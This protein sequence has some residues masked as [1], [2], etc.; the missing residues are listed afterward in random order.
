MDI[1]AIVLVVEGLIAHL[2]ILY[3]IFHFFRLRYK[4][5]AFKPYSNTFSIL[6][7]GILLLNIGGSTTKLDNAFPDLFGLDLR[8][9]IFEPFIYTSTYITYIG[10]WILGNHYLINQ[11]IKIPIQRRTS[12]FISQRLLYILLFFLITI[13]PITLGTFF[14]NLLGTDH[15]T[16]IYTIFVLISQIS[17]FTF[18]FY[19]KAL[20][21]EQE[22]NI[23]KLTKARIDLVASSAL[24]Q[25]AISIVIF[26]SALLGF[27]VSPENEIYVEIGLLNLVHI[28][29][30]RTCLKFYQAFHL[31]KKVRMKYGLTENRYMEFSVGLSESDE[32]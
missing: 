16:I 25:V 30:I 24:Y 23:S 10:L 29:S 14:T 5:P 9:I 1:L 31:P 18:L 6:S 21:K 12:F 11:I 32:N 22:A 20:L 15:N 8:T 13:I 28:I 4:Y 27:I 3:F 7:L 26:L 2:I 19:R 17:M